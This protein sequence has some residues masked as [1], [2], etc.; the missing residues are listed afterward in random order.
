MLTRWPSIYIWRKNFLKEVDNIF[1]VQIRDSIIHWIDSYWASILQQGQ[2]LGPKHTRIKSECSQPTEGERQ[3]NC[4]VEKHKV[5]K[6]LP[7]VGTGWGRDS[8]GQGPGQRRPILNRALKDEQN[9][10]LKQW[11][12]AHSRKIKQNSN[13]LCMSGFKLLVSITNYCS[14]ECM[15]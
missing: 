12:A 14:Q 4:V 3:V 2:V 10:I 7:G 13:A 8:E 1:T 6:E 5:L 9:E 11:Y 15:S